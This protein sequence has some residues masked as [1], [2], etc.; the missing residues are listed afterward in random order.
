MRPDGR[1][2]QLIVVA[3]VVA[4]VLGASRGSWAGS[5]AQNAPG[6]ALAVV[7]STELAAATTS[8]ENAQGPAN[9]VSQTCTAI[10]SGATSCAPRAAPDTP[11]VS[12]PE[13]TNLT[14][15][16]VPLPGPRISEMTWDASDGYVL[17]YGGLGS[18]ADMTWATTD[19]WSYL[20]GTWTNLTTEVAGGPP[21]TSIASSMAY[22]PWTS[23]VV[24]FGG[25]S[26]K[27][28][29]LSLTWTYHA[30]VWTNI[31]ATAGSPP[32]PRTL[33][34]FLADLTSH[35]MIL[36][37]GEAAEP[38]ASTGVPYVD[39]WLFS[40]TAWSN[41]SGS[42]GATPPP[43][44]DAN[45][46]Y[47]PAEAGIVL[48]GT[49]VE[50]PPYF[51][52]TYL[53]AGGL[54]KNLTP[55][56]AGGTPLLV[57]PGLAYVAATNSVLAIDSL[58]YTSNSG[59]EINY[60]VEWEFNAGNWTNITPTGFFPAC[61][62]GA[63]VATDPSGAIYA[64]GGG[65]GNPGAPAYFTQW[66][67]A[68]S[69]GPLAAV[70]AT[71]SIED[72]GGSVNISGTFSGGLAPFQT[73]L[74]FG[75]GGSESGNLSAT[76]DYQTTGVF[77][78]DINVTDLVGRTATGTATVTVNYAPSVVIHAG[79]SS[80]SVGT[81]INFTSSITGG[82]PTFTSA[83]NFGDGTTSTSAAVNHS[84]ATSGTFSVRL[85]VTDA[86]GRTATS[87]IQ[88]TVSPASW[89]IPPLLAGWF[90]THSLRGS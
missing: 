28:A 65:Y 51:G 42:V 25:E 32:S 85:V 26:L 45:A 14:N 59:T 50:G 16:V 24:L 8:M 53:F 9:G 21:P 79:P 2:W 15:H 78:V 74:S 89:V 63:T 11:S 88:L 5:T 6:S 83:W 41:I 4:S 81:A 19:T 35:Q 71:P 57:L 39:T 27:N 1:I 48:L 30:K 33:A 3:V 37:G 58:L 70:K 75:D 60:P 54:W 72:L 43:M 90:C 10:S 80:P 18:L 17:L 34:P 66:M 55:S 62:S 47:D 46:V 29:N 31:T 38:A 13:W 12:S 22:D 23:E 86:T 82:T 73:K 77:D 40:G 7:G 76:H 56:E 44:E 61:G 49:N 52:D 67:Y 64:F 20:N 69:S 84:Y 36:Y 87:S 68:Y